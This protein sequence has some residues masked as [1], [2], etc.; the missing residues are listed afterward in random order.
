MDR[1]GLAAQ[2]IV[3]LASASAGRAALLRSAGISP[4]V[5]VSEVDERALAE[6]QGPMAND[7][8]HLTTFLASAKATAVA[9]RI[10]AGG[11]SVPNP[12][13]RRPVLVVGADSML[14]FAGEVLGKAASTE[15]VRARWAAFAGNAGDLVTGHAVVE[16]P[17]GRAVQRAVR[18][19]VLA[20]RP[21]PAELAAYIA[22]GEPLGVAGSCTLDGFGAAFIASI[23]GDPSNV[24]GLSLPNLR[25]MLAEL[26]YQWTDLWTQSLGA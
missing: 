21:S 9:H 3:V 25:L 17:S 1:P 6:Q 19:R 8:D 12:T 14:W 5:C 23:E 26:G 4:V 13:T 16:L 7:P 20:A 2:P 11:T 24:I 10:V 15:E 22:T 18:T